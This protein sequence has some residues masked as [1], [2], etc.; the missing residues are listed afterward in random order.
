MTPKVFSR[1]STRRVLTM[2][3]LY[4]IP[5]TDR[6]QFL[7]STDKPQTVLGAAFET[8]LASVAGC[9]LFHADLHAG[10]LLILGDG[11]VGFIDFGIVGRISEKTKNGVMSLI[12]AMMVKDYPTIARS[13]LAIGMTR[14]KWIPQSWQR[15]WKTFT[16][17]VKPMRW[18]P[19]RPIPRPWKSLNR[20]FSIWSALPKPTASGS[21][22]S[23][24]CF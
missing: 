14:K 13:M 4:G 3:R 15:I 22:G 10:N 12:Q 5:L 1:A 20:F 2:E 6:E 18:M 9:E 24:P 17:P 23:S 11:R 7:K 16:M 21:P 19:C 8:W